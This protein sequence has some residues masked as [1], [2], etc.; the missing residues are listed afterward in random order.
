MVKL[1]H[2]HRLLAP[3]IAF[4]LSFSATHL[5]LS[6]YWCQLFCTGCYCP[7][8]SKCTTI[9]Q[10]TGKPSGPGPPM[11]SRVSKSDFKPRAMILKVL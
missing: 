10:A 5:L 3:M 7:T 6:V 4:S 9:Y 1:G 2:K 8:C 11:L